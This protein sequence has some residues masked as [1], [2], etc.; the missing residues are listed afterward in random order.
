MA[1]V[2]RKAR[3]GSAVTGRS[4]RVPINEQIP[5]RGLTRRPPA[6]PDLPPLTKRR[7]DTE[8]IFSAG[9]GVI[10]RGAFVDPDFSPVE[11]DARA[12]AG[13]T[14]GRGFANLATLG[15]FGPSALS[16]VI[17]DTFSRENNAAILSRAINSS[18]LEE[19]ELS[20]A[21][22]ERTGPQA[23][24]FDPFAE[25]SQF[26]VDRAETGKDFDTG[27]GP[28]ADSG[29]AA[30]DIDAEIGG[31]DF[32]DF[33]DFDDFGDFDDDDDDDDGDK[34]LC[35]EMNRQG[36][37]SDKLYRA[38]SQYA[39]T[40]DREIIKGYHLWAKPLVKKMKK[41]P[42][43]VI[44]ARPLVI[45]WAEHMAYKMNVIK[46]DN[47]I[48]NILETIGAPICKLIYFIKWLG[49]GLAA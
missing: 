20:R 46:N 45:A 18:F 12:Q 23:P 31:V 44:M 39:K 2:F 47:M 49:I 36:F 28:E 37:L 41:S 11:E 9:S 42:L 15:V 29:F 27:T 35:G 19:D 34:V 33:D 24:E 5:Q 10:G 3:Q 25:V 40:M 1:T 43:L 26:D 8:D 14:T 22:R 4:I 13:L 17:A 6:V 16:G 30:D 21:G 7:P 48:G 38:D 32:D